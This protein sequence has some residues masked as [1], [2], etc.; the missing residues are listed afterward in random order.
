MQMHTFY[1]WSFYGSQQS[2]DEEMIKSIL[3]TGTTLHTT[4]ETLL[5]QLNQTESSAVEQCVTLYR[6]ISGML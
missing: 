4:F 1:N 3:S 5:G 2:L 6:L